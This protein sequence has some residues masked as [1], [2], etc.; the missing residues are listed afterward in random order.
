MKKL[1]YTEI[2]DSTEERDIELVYKN[3]IKAHFKNSEITYPFKCDG[4]LEE[5]LM[6]DDVT[7][8]LRLI[9]EFKYGLDFNISINRAKVLVQVIFYLKKF[10]LRED[11][12]YMDMPNVILAGDKTTCFI[13]SSNDVQ[14]YLDRKLD[15]SIAPS[16][17]PNKYKDLTL[18]ISN[19]KSLNPIIF[20]I[21]KS[22]KFER[23]ALDIKRLIIDIKTKFKVTESN[24]LETYD[25]FIERIIKDPSKC[26]ASDLVQCFI[27]TILGEVEISQKK[28]SKFI[29]KKDRRIEI[30]SFNYKQFEEEYSIK[31]SIEEKN[32]F[33]SIKDRLTEDTKRRFNG[34]FFTPTI[35]VN[36]AHRELCYAFGENWK[37]EYVVWDCAWGTGNLTRDYY[38]KELYCSTLDKIDLELGDSYNKTSHKFVY[39]FLNDNPELLTYN[40]INNSLIPKPLYKAFIENKPLIFFINPPFAEGSNGKQGDKESKD[41]ISNT[42][43]KYM[44]ERENLKDSSQQLYIQFLYRILKFKQVF[45]LDNLNIGIFTPT[46]FL[47]GERSEKFR[48]LFLKNFKFER[49]IVF[50]ASH[51][52]NVSSQW[53]VGFSIWSSGECEEKN[54][55]KFLIKELSD[56][57]KIESVGQKVI[58]NLDEPER[59]SSWINNKKFAN[60]IETITLKSAMTLD[61][62]T[63]MVDENAIAFLMND[64]NNVYANTQGVY[65]LSAP[66]TRHVKITPI[67]RE[68]YKKCCCLFT[69]RKVIKSN[70]LNQKDNYMIPK[71]N[72]LE[73]KQYESDSIIYSIFANENGISSF[74]DIKTD[75]KEFNIKNEMFFMSLKEIKDLANINRNEAIYNDCLRFNKE[76]FMYAELKEIELSKEGKLILETARKLVWESFKHRDEF[77]KLHPKYNINTWDAGWYQIKFLL[78]ECT[79]KDLELFEDMIKS[80]ENKLRPLIYEL[81]F[82]K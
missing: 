36:E 75:N 48:E 43:V 59:L 17:A 11:K 30:D 25:Y 81:G 24:I 33:I 41:G 4:Y 73:F 1:F 34:E 45:N 31:Y 78:N 72:I 44:M 46:L 9:M 54:N 79:K 55:F 2:K 70:W 68:N 77:N 74:R 63:R 62:K 64:S 40:K 56:N 14:A 42:K 69:A 38:F 49:G 47:S 32:K 6:Y 5:T 80:F 29:A 52:S 16:E 20:N 15:W 82:L 7:K 53:G 12:K 58:Y 26:S 50:N 10:T 61:K 76:S 28:N 8:V 51:F 21:D 39:D 57:G 23:V 13:I 35:W 71:I 65:I 3:N 66:V 27:D 37:K 22:F 67:T 60:K 18:E 19:N